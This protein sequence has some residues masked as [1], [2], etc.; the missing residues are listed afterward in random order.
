MT[1]TATELS[2]EALRNQLRSAAPRPVYLLY[3]E[4]DLLVAEATDAIIEA[5]LGGGDP[6]F[7]LDVLYGSDVDGND[8]VARA[9]AF[10]M[11]SER[12]SVVVR[13]MEKLTDRDTLLPYLQNPAPTTVLVLQ[14][15][16]PDF[17]TTLFKH[18][19]DS[20]VMV[21]C[22]RLYENELPEWITARV[23]R[24]GKRIE[25]DA[26]QLV[27]AYVGRS[28]REIDNELEKMRTF[29]GEAPSITVEHV[30]E[31]TGLTRDHTIFELQKAIGRNDLR[32]SLSILE[33]MLRNGESAIGIVVML[34]KYFQKLMI[35][36]DPEKSRL[37]DAGVARYLGLRETQM[38]ELRDYRQAA[39]A[40]PPRRLRKCFE[41][42][43]SADEQLK[44]SGEE[45][46]VM[47]LALHSILDP[48][49]RS[50]SPAAE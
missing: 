17:R 2:V 41:E 11:M 26:A 47:M 7:N 34:T 42:L 12:R 29:V 36:H 28:L 44:L 8:V 19:R 18:L 30:R 45:R 43:L 25:P 15:I 1:G 21:K 10:P 4:E 50:G 22:R 33:H 3:G 31:I 32:R 14:A 24:M 13:E 39:G 49:S 37:N 27:Q 48:G 6:S 20:A 35:L 23:R 5:A 16:K 38:R 9:V 46:T 40:F